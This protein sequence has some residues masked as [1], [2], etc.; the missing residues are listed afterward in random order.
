M[1]RRTIIKIIP[2]III[3][4]IAYP[5]PLNAR[6]LALNELVEVIGSAGDALIK[7]TDGIKHLVITGNEGY[8]Y[9]AAKRERDRL[10]SISK[11]INNLTAH[12]NITIIQSLDQYI[13]I[14][15]PTQ[16]DWEAVVSNFHSVLTTLHKLLSD[17]ESENSDFVLQ[18]AYLA[19]NQSLNSR[20]S[21]LSTLARMSPP[22]SA[23]EK[24]VL[25]KANIKYQELRDT[26]LRALDELNK[27]IE[28]H[29]KT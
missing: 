20:A 5:A 2:L 3:S 21:L 11:K 15:H 17:I 10:I 7:L 18:P 16:S 26:T 8:E 12:Q 19:I 9:I 23:E 29:S 22:R 25:K 1:H 6:I 4:P 24:L 13:K 28:Q 14:E 27:Y